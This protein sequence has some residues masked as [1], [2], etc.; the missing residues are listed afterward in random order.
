M[1]GYLTC[2][3][4]MYSWEIV[5]KIQKRPVFWLPSWILDTCRSQKHLNNVSGRFLIPQNICLDTLLVFLVC[6]V[7]KLWSKY[8]NGG[9][10]G[11]HLGF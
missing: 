7:R 3:F 6:T 10:F 2:V 4:N 5:I 1:F 11:R 9:H 8:E